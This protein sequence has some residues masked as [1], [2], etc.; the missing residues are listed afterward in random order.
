M[1]RDLGLAEPADVVEVD[2]LR[3]THVGP[4][5]RSESRD[6]QSYD[7]GPETADA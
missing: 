4:S 5:R 3:V 1:A 2:F 6:G 7:S